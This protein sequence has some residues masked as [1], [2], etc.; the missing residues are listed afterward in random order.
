MS[1]N[2]VNI[3]IVGAGISGLIAAKVLEENGF[4][5]VI[6]ESSNRAGGRVKTDIIDGYQLDRGFQVLL[7]DYPAAKKFLDFDALALQ[8]FVP[9]AVIFYNGKKSIMGDAFRDSSL[10]FS[11]IFSNA[12]S[13]VDKLKVLKLNNQLKKKKLDAIFLDDEK[14]TY[15]YLI[16][17]GFSDKIIN[18]FFKPFFG[19][20]FLESELTTSSRMF[21]FVYKMFGEGLAVLPKGGIEE[22]SKQLLNSLTKTTFLFNRKVSSV[23]DGE[24]L[25]SN[26]D[27]ILSNYTII[28]TDPSPMVDNLKNQKVNWKSCQ[29]LYFTCPKK[30]ISKPIIGLVA[31]K[32]SLVNN[33]FF[34][35]S[36]SVENRN[37]QELLS[38]TVIK[39]HQLSEESLVKKI[40]DDLNTFCLIT[41]AKFLHS[42]HIPMALP[43]LKNIQYDLNPSET[44]LTDTLFI[45]GDTLLNGSLNAAMISGEKAA[46]GLLEK[47]S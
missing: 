33:I 11:T 1:K 28:A 16:D 8:K 32:E 3:H 42:Y 44:Q 34:H 41:E 15:Q 47:L 25:L 37:E 17:F 13:I 35:T 23:K 5:P 31:D 7:T 2:N 24:I 19:G 36:I 26:G 45:A 30:I 12:G 38:V 20:I 43:N 29:T 22:I 14:T 10:L 9:G 39:K 21:E 6:I 46:L 4:S 27:K 40:Q 18:R